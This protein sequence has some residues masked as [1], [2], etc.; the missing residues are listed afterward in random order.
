M[1]AEL[2]QA[3]AEAAVTRTYFWGAL[4][5]DVRIKSVT[6]ATDGTVII[7]WSQP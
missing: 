3:L 6:S 5:H 1:I 2:V 4:G 7:E